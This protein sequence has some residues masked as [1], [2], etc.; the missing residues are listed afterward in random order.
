M[1]KQTMNILLV[2][3]S[4]VTCE[5][6]RNI[7]SDSSETIDFIIETAGDLVGAFDILD[8]KNFDAVLLD[9]GLPDSSGVETV[10]KVHALKPEVPLIV[11]TGSDND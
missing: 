11:L 3:D 7:L 2:D 5:L 9:L 4:P 10:K 6:V 8:R 1:D